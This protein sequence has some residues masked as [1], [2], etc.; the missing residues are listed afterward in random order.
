MAAWRS[1]LRT[2]ALAIALVSYG[3]I[4]STALMQT[5]VESQLSELLAE[6]S[7]CEVRT[8]LRGG[9]GRGDV[10]ALI[11]ARTSRHGRADRRQSD[12]KV[13]ERLSPG[14]TLPLRC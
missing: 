11:S 6:T 3:A 12:A 4:P 7:S 2:G 9:A 8:R 10:A 5:E 14:A 1:M 13:N